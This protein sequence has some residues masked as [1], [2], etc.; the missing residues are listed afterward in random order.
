MRAILLLA[1]TLAFSLTQAQT[2]IL[3]FES[4]ETSSLFQYFGSTI[5]GDTTSIIA[6]PDMSG[7]NVSD[8]V[9]EFVKPVEAQVWAG[10]YSLGTFS[11]DLTSESDVCVDVWYGSPGNLALKLENGDQANWITTQ[12]VTDS[13][14]WVQVCFNTLD[15]SEEDP[16][17]SAA[18][19][20]YTTITLFTD[21]GET[22]EADRTYYLDNFVTKTADAVPVDVTFSVDMNQYEGS[23]DT[24]YVSG[25]FNDWAGDANP[26]ED[27]DGDG[28]WTG[29][30]VD[31]PSG[32]HEYKFQVDKWA[33]D[34]KLNAYG[35]CTK[36]DPSGQF[37]NRV[38]VVQDD[39]VL[40][41]VC[42]ARCYACDEGVLITINLGQGGIEVSEDGFFI[43][44]GGNFGNPGDFSLDDSDGDGIHTITVE[45]PVGFSSY[46][47][48][49]NGACADF[50]CKENIAG[51][52]CADPDNFNDRFMGPVMQDTVISTCFE[53]CRDDTGCTVVEPRQVSFTV[54][55]SGYSEAFTQVYV[56][57]TFN[58]WSGDANPLTD[59]GDGVWEGS[60]TVNPGNQEYK[61]QVDGW[62]DQE[63]FTD[64]DPC[65]VT[66]PS[67]QFINR[68]LVVDD[69]DLNICFLWNTCDMCEASGLNTIETRDDLFTAV[70]TV[71][72]NNTI[73]TFHE[74]N[75]DKELTVL[76]SMGQQVAA[77]QIESGQ[78]QYD[79]DLGKL[80]PGIYFLN[81]RAGNT[82]QTT[83]LLIAK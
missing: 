74:T 51:Q 27:T 17:T 50:S 77:M 63:F 9:L 55:M 78:D 42:F 70:P 38:L 15:P 5:D 81:V 20:V 83:R 30:V 43:A 11:V 67:G 54:D 39:T 82:Q 13:M 19:G 52:D 22:P 37:I 72:S 75:T 33:D 8:N 10:A 47:T 23:F 41:T 73:V 21:F 66:D 35:F 1:C 60:L 65:T 68:S 71:I 26:L 59:M 24:V 44:G 45:H 56:S 49:T 36:V 14:Q 6:N 29:T 28:V 7:I 25:T 79:L 69:Q 4:E 40:D 34:E 2:V 76:T 18:G 62:T 53:E 61:F 16:F 32:P 57:G 31:M 64:G 46:Y 80:V 12:E 58:G 3:D 48:F